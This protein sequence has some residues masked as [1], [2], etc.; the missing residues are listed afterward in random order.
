VLVDAHDGFA[1][2][3]DGTLPGAANPVTGT[4]VELDLNLHATV[5]THD[6]ACGTIIGTA[7]SLPAEG[8]TF[9]SVRIPDDQTL[10]APVFACPAD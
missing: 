8:S 5:R 9:G 6:F 2:D 7:G 10:P 4:D 3:L 1:I